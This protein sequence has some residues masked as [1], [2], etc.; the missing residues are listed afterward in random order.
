MITL[1]KNSY[2]SFL[3]EIKEKIH[4]A[5]YAAMR[6]LNT[7]L[8]N[9]YW[10]IGKSIVEKQKQYGWGKS[11]VETLSKDLQN[12]FPG[13]QGYSVQN[14]W[15]MRQLYSE[16]KDN[17][18]LQPMVGEISWSNNLVILSK[19]KAD[20]EREFYIQMAKKYGWT[21]NVL[22]HQIE[23]K[24]YEKF[25]LNQANFES[26]VPEKFK[27]QAILAVKDEYNFDFLDLS[28]ASNEKDLELALLKNIRQFLSEMG[29][30]FAFIGNQY[31]LQVGDEDFYIDL[32]LYHRK[33]KSLVVIELK[34]GKFK[35]EYAGKMNFYLAVL[36]DK[37]KQ[38]D[39][40]PSIGIII[41]KG[42]SKT[43]VEYALKKSSSPIGVASYTLTET[44]PK[45]Y[46]GLLPT[47]KEIEDKLSGFIEKIAVG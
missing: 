32:L 19:C 33:L 16:Y 30:D 34:A 7:S 24:S 35:P 39:E 20:L 5:Q 46:K 26:A 21:K 41:C 22:I 47:P 14:L 25:L 42:K 28:E 2:Y 31:R 36:D 15:Y 17:I 11:V 10:E 44:L 12:E 6:Q 43:V 9:L 3:K 45:E 23:G 27:H 13:A 38:A 40:N 37:V 4:Q 29:A 8:I 18:K 1:E